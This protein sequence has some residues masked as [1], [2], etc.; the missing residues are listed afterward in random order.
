MLDDNIQDVITEV[1]PFVS[2][3]IWLGLPNF[4]H[5]RLKMN[6]YRDIETFNKATELLDV[7]NLDFVKKLFNTFKED[8][9]IKWKESIKK[10][11]SK[12]QNPAESSIL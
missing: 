10:I 8:P 11:D 5:R 1:R 12:N 9:V 6:G 2:K 4:L 7:L 3:S